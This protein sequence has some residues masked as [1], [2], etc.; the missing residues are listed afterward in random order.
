MG[1]VPSSY[2]SF[3]LIMLK[4]GMDED[5]DHCLSLLVIGNPSGTSSSISLT[6]M[7][8]STVPSMI[9]HHP[10][11]VSREWSWQDQ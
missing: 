7:S 5:G 4:I 8:R 6:C 2:V 3:L 11:M 9:L 10:A 1:N